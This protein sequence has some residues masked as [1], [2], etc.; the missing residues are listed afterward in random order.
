M[1]KTGPPAN[2]S[3]K[4]FIGCSY[5]G[6]EVHLKLSNVI[7]SVELYTDIKNIVPV[8][9]EKVP[10]ITVKDF[11]VPKSAD[12]E[13]SEIHWKKNKDSVWVTT[14]DKTFDYETEYGIEIV[15]RAK[16]SARK[17]F[18][19][20]ESGLFNVYWNN[21]HELISAVGQ[22]TQTLKFVHSYEK[23]D[24]KEV[25]VT[26]QTDYNKAKKLFTVTTNH[27]GKFTVMLIDFDG[28]KLG[29]IH[30]EQIEFTASEPRVIN[31]NEIF[32][33]ADKII[34]VK[35]EETLTPLCR[36]TETK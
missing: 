2:I 16:K 34:L 26:A 1:V 10:E 17:S 8:A 21:K 36:A 28:N 35:S 9:S 30:K 20:T 24:K 33:N 25:V 3:G 6:N 12:Y 15:L 4:F 18:Y 5:L 29:N 32:P 31:I 13:I 19:S 27:S 7:D 22:N 14:N 23:T 11:Y